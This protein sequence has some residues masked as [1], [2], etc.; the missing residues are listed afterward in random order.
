MQRSPF[1]E[2]DLV[3]VVGIFLLRIKNLD[4]PFIP[5]FRIRHHS[6]IAHFS[7]RIFLRIY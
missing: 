6:L 3:P 5:V 2:P 4:I 7:T 1:I